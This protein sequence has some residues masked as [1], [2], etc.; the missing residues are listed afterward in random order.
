GATKGVEKARSVSAS[1]M[2]QAEVLIPPMDGIKELQG[3]LYDNLQAAM[4]GQKSVEQAIADAA[5]AWD[6]R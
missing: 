2:T 1:Q 5:A 4:L 6:G 3:I